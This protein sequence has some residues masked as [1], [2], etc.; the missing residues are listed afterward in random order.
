MPCRSD[1]VGRADRNL[2]DAQGAPGPGSPAKP[3]SIPSRMRCPSAGTAPCPRPGHSNARG[4]SEGR[5]EV[6][7]NF[8]TAIAGTRRAT[9]AFYKI[10]FV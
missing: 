4:D 10:G 5:D 9:H 1:R 2:E 7:V 3:M 6:A 8:E